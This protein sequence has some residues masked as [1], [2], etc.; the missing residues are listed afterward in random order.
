M[1]SR[2]DL[3]YKLSL[4]LP[5]KKKKEKKKLWNIQIFNFLLWFEILF[6]IILKILLNQKN[7]LYTALSKVL[8]QNSKQG[9]SR[10]KEILQPT[11]SPRKDL[12]WRETC[13]HLH[14]KKKF[15]WL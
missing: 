8:Q 13:L 15:A 5:P 11:R 7:I 14:E 4:P 10:P 12:W 9:I 2:K 6:F 1:W 3:Q